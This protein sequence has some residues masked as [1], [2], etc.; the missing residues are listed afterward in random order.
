ML[1]TIPVHFYY[2]PHCKC[3]KFP[4]Y[5]VTISPN[6][7]PVNS[8]RKVSLSDT[9]YL[10]YTPQYTVTVSP[11]VTAVHSPS[12]LLLLA[13]KYLLYNPPVHCYC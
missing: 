10:L 6:L 1:Y 5:N 11:N 3:C 7:P 12:T 2:L 8:P 13:P 9:E 4:Q